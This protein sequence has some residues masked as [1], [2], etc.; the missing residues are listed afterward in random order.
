MDKLTRVPVQTPLVVAGAYREPEYNLHLT[1]AEAVYLTG[2]L[3]KTSSADRPAQTLFDA[4]ADEFNKDAED[5]YLG[6]SESNNMGGYRWRRIDGAITV[7]P[8][9]ELYHDTPNQL[10]PPRHDDAM[11]ALAVAAELGELAD[12][13]GWGEEASSTFRNAIQY[14]RELKDLYLKGAR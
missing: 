12:Y 1:K 7:R 5:L 2:L 13:P 8:W 3:G 14:L 10:D 9:D 4:L 11:A 6:R